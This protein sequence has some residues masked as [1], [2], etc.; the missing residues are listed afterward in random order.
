MKSMQQTLLSI[1]FQTKAAKCS[2]GQFELIRGIFACPNNIST[3]LNNVYVKYV[4]SELRKIRPN[5][6]SKRDFAS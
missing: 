5:M 2:H 4:N 3:G 6:T 1:F